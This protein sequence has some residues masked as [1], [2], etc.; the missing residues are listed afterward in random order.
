MTAL[1]LHAL[2]GEGGPCIPGDGIPCSGMG[3]RLI[4]RVTSPSLPL[5]IPAP[6]LPSWLWESLQ[7]CCST[8]IRRWDEF[9]IFP[10]PQNS[11]PSR[12]P[13]SP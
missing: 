9:S 10:F 4:P 6:A 5:Q 13:P 2:S 1:G 8:G 12:T 7:H 11:I 3:W